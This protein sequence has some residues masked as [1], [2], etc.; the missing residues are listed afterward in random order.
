MTGPASTCENTVLGVHISYAVQREAYLPCDPNTGLLQMSIEASPAPSNCSES[1][2]PAAANVESARIHAVLTGASASAP[3][4]DKGM[5]VS[6]VRVDGR[7]PLHGGA[8]Q[9]VSMVSTC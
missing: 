9:V 7:C 4:S 6:G 5:F 3:D 2:A 1:D 8:K